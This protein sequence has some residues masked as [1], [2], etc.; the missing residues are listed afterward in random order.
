[1]HVVDIARPERHIDV[2]GM[3]GH[4]APKPRVGTAAGVATSQRGGVILASHRHAPHGRGKT[5][6]S[7]LRL[8]H[9]KNV[10]NDWPLEPGGTQS[11]TTNDGHTSPLDSQDGLPLLGL[12]PCTD[13]EW[14]SRRVPATP[15]GATI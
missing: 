13:E 8:E 9:H 6:H 2:T 12:R 4:E 1:M 15:P 5:T 7:S 10:V 14:D 11:I 3:D